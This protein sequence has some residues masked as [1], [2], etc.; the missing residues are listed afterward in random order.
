LSGDPFSSLRR[1]RPIIRSAINYLLLTL[2]ALLIVFWIRSY[3][4]EDMWHRT[5]SGWEFIKIS[6][7]TV[8]YYLKGYIN[9]AEPWHHERWSYEGWRG[10]G[11]ERFGVTYHNQSKDHV[12]NASVSLAVL[13]LI[14]AFVPV[15]SLIIQRR[16][17]RRA[18]AGHCSRCGY[19]LR[20]TPEM[21]PECGAAPPHVR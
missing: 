12:I 15:T 13:T 18:M 3:F 10:D 20:A 1:V 19:D 9:P 5:D 4:V 11:W 17:L 14:A 6:G 21:C 16:Q 2:V 8:S 7:G